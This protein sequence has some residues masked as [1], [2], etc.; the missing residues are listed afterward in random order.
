MSKFFKRKTEG[1][2]LVEL[3]IAIVILGI[4][5]PSLALLFSQVMKTYGEP[6]VMQVATALAE[7]K[8]EEVTSLRYSDIVDDGPTA[9]T[10]NFSNYTWQVIVSAVPTSLANDPA[11]DDYKK[12]EVAVSSNI[13]GSVTL[14]TIVTNN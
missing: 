14:T 6:E 8:M 3:V 9:F 5:L 2:S 11:M 13:I 12:I 7:Q 1:F 4:C 10:G